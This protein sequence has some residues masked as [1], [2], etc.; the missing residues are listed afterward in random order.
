MSE[1]RKKSGFTLGELP[2]FPNTFCWLVF[3]S[4]VSFL[5]T[6]IKGYFMTSH[7]PK[8]DGMSPSK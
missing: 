2:N 4:A 8:G 6:N 3:A 1:K 5:T 7:P